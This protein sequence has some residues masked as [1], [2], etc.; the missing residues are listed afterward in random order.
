MEN[1]ALI[2]WKIRK[3]RPDPK[4]HINGQIDRSCATGVMGEASLPTG[5]TASAGR[6]TGRF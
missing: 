1:L 4:L 2:T 3:F 5:T 6:R